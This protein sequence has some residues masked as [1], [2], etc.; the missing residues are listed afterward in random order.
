MIYKYPRYDKSYIYN[1]TKEKFKKG[2]EYF[3][4]A[5]YS[6]SEE[7]LLTNDYDIMKALDKDGDLGIYLKKDGKVMEQPIS[8]GFEFKDY[9]EEKEKS[10]IINNLV[11]EEEYNILLKA[12]DIIEKIL[13]I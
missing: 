6:T 12:K 10:S 1:G 2:E 9:F 11:T 8:F 3:I 7:K 13:G 5:I 4:S